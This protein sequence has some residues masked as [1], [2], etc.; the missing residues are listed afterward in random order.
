MAWRLAAATCSKAWL[1]AGLLLGFGLMSLIDL[2]P[3]LS[4]L[5]KVALVWFW[6]MAASAAVW[7]AS[8]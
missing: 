6:L 3:S 5:A 1:A 4:A 2:T 8:T 7:A